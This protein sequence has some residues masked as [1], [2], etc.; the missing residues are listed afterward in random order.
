LTNRRDRHRKG[1]RAG[2]YSVPA[3][4]FLPGLCAASAE[5]QAL[6]ADGAL[7]PSAPVSLAATTVG[8]LAAWWVILWLSRRKP[9]RLF[10]AA[11]AGFFTGNLLAP[12]PLARWGAETALAAQVAL[13]GAAIAGLAILATGVILVWTLLAALIDRL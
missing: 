6:P 8:L 5:A 11:M 9:R 10:A 1:P 7:T 4:A 2:P 3:A 13:Y 12:A